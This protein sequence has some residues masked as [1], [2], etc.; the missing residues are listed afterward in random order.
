MINITKHIDKLLKEEFDFI[1]R[2]I[3]KREEEIK[4]K[5]L[6]RIKKVQNTKIWKG[7]LELKNNES[8]T[9]LGNLEVVEGSLDLFKCK[10]LTSLGN[11]KEIKGGLYLSYS[12]INY[13]PEN[14]IIEDSIAKLNEYNKEWKS[15][16]KIKEFNEWHR[17]K[18]LLKE[19]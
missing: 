15:P 17:R 1:P 9:D 10:N 19:E 14:I 7:D 5:E 8:L 3:E 12:G 16:N 2:N 18:G 6:E 4:Q 11:L 13:I